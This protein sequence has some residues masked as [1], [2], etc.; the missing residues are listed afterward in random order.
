MKNM[1]E[2]TQT[3]QRKTP[4]LRAYS[5]DLSR[6]QLA[7]DPEK[8]SGSTRMNLGILRCTQKNKK[9]SNNLVAK[10]WICRGFL[11]V[12]P[13]SYMGVWHDFGS[14]RRFWS[15]QWWLSDPREPTQALSSLWYT[16][17]IGY[18]I[19]WYLCVIRGIYVSYESYLIDPPSVVYHHKIH[20]LTPNCSSCS[21]RT[22]SFAF[23]N[24]IS[25]GDWNIIEVIP[26]KSRSP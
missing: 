24:A 16:C 18:N 22:T 14:R 19:P 21:K 25:Q 23:A 3:K 15:W 17:L 1:N 11:F 20:N 26:Y 2:T 6:G 13:L 5:R 12:C 8:T 4:P 10:L 7:C 9:T